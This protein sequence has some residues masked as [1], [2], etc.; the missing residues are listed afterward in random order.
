MF[1]SFDTT[2]TVKEKDRGKWWCDRDLVKIIEL[3]ANNLCE[4][5]EKY[6][7]IVNDGTGIQIS[8]NAIQQ[9]ENMYSDSRSFGKN[10]QVGYVLTGSTYFENN[11]GD[12]I[13][14]F[15]DLWIEIRTI[16]YPS[17]E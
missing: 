12:M 13:K 17:F 10:H 3:K 7:Q 2:T 4:A 15:V 9:K 14:K 1:Y 16:T 8:K 11:N 5:L 6:R